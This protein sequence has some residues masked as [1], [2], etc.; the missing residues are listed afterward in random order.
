MSGLSGAELALRAVAALS[1]SRFTDE[2]LCAFNNGIQTFGR[3]PKENLSHDHALEA[4]LIDAEGKPC[5]LE[6]LRDASALV[7]NRRFPA[8]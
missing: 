2:E 8:A 6:S 4:G 3:I 5:D 1:L 7:V